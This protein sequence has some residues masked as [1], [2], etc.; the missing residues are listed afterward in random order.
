MSDGTLLLGAGCA[1]IALA[2]AAPR[3]GA[4]SCDADTSK[5][6]PLESR[7]R[8]HLHA[9]DSSSS[10]SS[11]RSTGASN[12]ARRLRA[13]PGMRPSDGWKKVQARQYYCTA[14]PGYVWAATINLAPLLWIRGWDSYLKGVGLGVQGLG[15]GGW[16]SGCGLRC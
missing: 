13:S 10:S 7:T 11:H 6:V 15:L 2:L 4:G 12:T 5:L 14:Q 9:H 3:C 1:T 8:M 16:A